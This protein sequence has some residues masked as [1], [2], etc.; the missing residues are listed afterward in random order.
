MV[1]RRQTVLA[2]ASKSSLQTRANIA[3]WAVLAQTEQTDQ[4]TLPHRKRV[5]IS[6]TTKRRKHRYALPT[7]RDRYKAA[8]A[9]V[10]VVFPNNLLIHKA[11]ISSVISVD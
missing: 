2:G 3:L 10:V 5:L 1:S 4:G 6:V 7:T 8:A 9:A 11:Q